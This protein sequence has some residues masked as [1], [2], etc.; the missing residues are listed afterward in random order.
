[1]ANEPHPK[2]EGK[3]SAKLTGPK[4][5]QV[6]P[7]LED[8][9]SIHKWLPSIDTCH[10]V[11]G[12]SGQPGCIRYCSSTSS[13]GSGSQMTSWVTERL[14]T[15]D[16]TDRSL[17]Y[18]VVDSN[19]GLNSYVATIKVSEEG[20]NHQVGCLIEWSFEV[21]PVKGWRLEDLVSYVDSSLQGMT[22]RMENALLAK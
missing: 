12:I 19:M 11:D 16:K 15:I 2:W 13:D 7:L 10:K 17:S 1:M 21:D 3:V 18:E 20:N 5:D 4:P 8:F 6:W 9:F 22:E 14:L